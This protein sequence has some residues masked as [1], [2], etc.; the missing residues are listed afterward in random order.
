MEDFERYGDYDDREDYEKKKSGPIITILK[1]CVFIVCFGVVALLGFRMLL[2]RTYPQDIKSIYFT[3]NLTEY[4]NNNNGNIGAK[5]QE[6]RAPY[7]N[8]EFANFF[9]DHLIVIE[10]VEELQISVR[11]NESAIPNMESKYNLTSLVAG[12]EDLLTFR[13]VD[14]NKNVYDN[15]VYAGYDS[16]MM[17]HY[18]KLVFDDV[19]FEDVKWIRLEIFVKAANSEEAF[20]MIPVY[21]NNSDYDSFEEY[22]LSSEEIPE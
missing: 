3:E 15:L 2:F 5:T 22:I 13:L 11:Y 4:Y 19:S 17:Y 1:I 9:C 7:D 21:E 18:V 14:N 8:P 12:S 10:G 16:K 6:L 20:A